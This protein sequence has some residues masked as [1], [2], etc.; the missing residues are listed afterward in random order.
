MCGCPLIQSCG[1]MLAFVIGCASVCDLTPPPYGMGGQETCQ[2]A[3]CLPLSAPES[4]RASPKLRTPRQSKVCS[5][6]CTCTSRLDC[7]LS[8]ICVVGVI[9]GRAIEQKMGIFMQCVHLTQDQTMCLAITFPCSEVVHNLF[10][11]VWVVCW[12]G[13]SL[14][15]Q[16]SSGISIRWIHTVVFTCGASKKMSAETLC[17]VALSFRAPGLMLAFVIGCASVCDLTPP[18]YGMGGQETCRQALCLP[19]SA[20][21]S[22]HVTPKLRTPRQS[23]VCSPKLHLHFP[24]GLYVVIHLRV[25]CH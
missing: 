9:G 20:P 25:R 4:I 18:P 1:L 13:N 5:Q 21:G 11:R 16:R 15:P 10:S 17:V 3:I 14:K 6:N 7:M 23:K 24:F 2:H 8:F 19:L 22:I 12:K